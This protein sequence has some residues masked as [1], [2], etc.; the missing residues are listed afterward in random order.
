[1]YRFIYTLL[2]LL[3]IENSTFAQ[4]EQVA[5]SDRLFQDIIVLDNRVL[6]AEFQEI[7]KSNDNGLTWD[8]LATLNSA[9][10]HIFKLVDETLFVGTSTVCLAYWI[11]PTG[12]SI[13]RSTDKGKTWSSVYEAQLGSTQIKEHNLY[14]F[15]NADDDF[16]RSEDDGSSW[17]ITPKFKSVVAIASNKN[18]VFV[19][20][21]Q[22]SIFISKDDGINWK[23]TGSG[24]PESTKWSLV[25]VD[26]TLFT[27]AG[28]IYRS[29]DNG[30][31]WSEAQTGIPSNLSV[32][33]LHLLGNYLY[34]TTW[35]SHIFRTKIS[36]IN[37]VDISEGME[38]IEPWISG[39][40]QND[41]YLFA[42]TSNGIWRRPISKIVSVY[43]TVAKTDVQKIRLFQ[44]HP[45]PFNSQTKFNFNLASAENV[46]ISIFNLKGQR[47]Q[48]LQLG[49]MALG[50]HS[51]IFRNDNLPS[52]LYFYQLQAG[53]FII[54]KKMLFIK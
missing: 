46:E 53:N 9:P 25:A 44:N 4:W 52:G 26:D 18:S 10:I 27:S 21:A 1:M 16:V 36:Q 13:L 15:A 6:V 37:W 43:R 2:F 42:A 54:R 48:V 39:L 22:D 14:I 3:V 34:A 8:S 40:D 20:I 5:F 45:N 33:N 7:H 12:P 49:F 38:I 23:S 29:T 47:V 19:S 31:N 17:G 30:Q 50:P 35:P 28:K 51:F 32:S 41:E 24:L 11:C